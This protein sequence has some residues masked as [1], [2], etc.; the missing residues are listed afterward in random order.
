MYRSVPDAATHLCSNVDR[1][2][3]E[4]R[5]MDV[6]ASCEALKERSPPSFRSLTTRHLP[7]H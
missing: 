3:N 6:V 2:R 4:I 5:H 1:L 7:R